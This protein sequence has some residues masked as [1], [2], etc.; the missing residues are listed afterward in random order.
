[1]TRMALLLLLLVPSVANAQQANEVPA[2]PQPVVQPTPAETTSSAPLAPDEPEAGG[3]GAQVAPAIL[4]RVQRRGG[5]PQMC[6]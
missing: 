6:C 1:M 2:L 3:M 4:I 5:C